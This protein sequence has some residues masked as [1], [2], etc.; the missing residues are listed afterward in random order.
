MDATPDNVNDLE[1]P[2]WLTPAMEQGLA[3]LEAK[4]AKIEAKVVDMLDTLE[5]QLAAVRTQANVAATLSAKAY[6]MQILDGSI[7]GFKPVPFLDGTYPA[8]HPGIATPICTLA[9]LRTLSVDES[10]V[11]YRGYFGENAAVPEDA[12]GRLEGIRLAVGCM[13]W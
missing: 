1:V 11:Y 3:P 2:A 5:R 6:N 8:D 10:V 7:E 12:E 13:A 9:E 4:I